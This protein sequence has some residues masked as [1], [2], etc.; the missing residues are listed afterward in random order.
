[1][2]QSFSVVASEVAATLI[3][4]QI[5]N[6]LLEDPSPIDLRHFSTKVHWSKNHINFWNL[7]FIRKVVC[8][9]EADEFYQIKSTFACVLIYCYICNRYTL[10]W[11]IDIF[12][13]LYLWIQ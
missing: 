2:L 4:H 9:A 8:V 6:P 10:Y 1:M 11:K 12:V 7:I 13:S 3:A 5:H